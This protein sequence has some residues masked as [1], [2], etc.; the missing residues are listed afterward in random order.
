MWLRGVGFVEA[1]TDW[2]EGI[3]AESNNTL[4]NVPV[5]SFSP[6]SQDVDVDGQSYTMTGLKKNT[7]HNFRVVANNKHGPGV[8][9]EDITVRTLSD[10]RWFSQHSCRTVLLQTGVGLPSV[11]F[12]SQC[13]ALLL[14]TSRWRSRTRR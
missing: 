8:S 4:M 3:P 1:L 11:S 10:G 2:A 5:L 6:P 13:P 12:P 9:T 7:E 14:R